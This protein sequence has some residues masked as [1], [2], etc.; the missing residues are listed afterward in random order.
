VAARQ[1]KLHV[2]H[3]ENNVSIFDGTRDARNLTLPFSEG[4][5]NAKKRL[6]QPHLLELQLSSN[7]LQFQSCEQATAGT[8]WKDY[9]EW[10]IV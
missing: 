5:A 10:T 8:F 6:F 1:W 4:S 3:F 2:V 9:P 7:S